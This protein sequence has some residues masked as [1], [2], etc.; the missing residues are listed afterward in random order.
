MAY[1]DNSLIIAFVSD[2]F[3]SSRIEAAA[4]ALDFHVLTIER[5][6]VIGLNNLDN[7]GVQYAEHLEVQAPRERSGQAPQ[8]QSGQAPQEQSGQGSTL[9]N[10]LT[11]P[12][13]ALII[14]D[15]GNGSISWRKWIPLIKSS[16]ATRRIPVLCFGAHMDAESLVA[17]RSAGADA[18]LARSKFVQSLAELLQKYARRIDYSALGEACQQKLSEIAIRGLDAFNR[19]EYFEAHE[20]LEEAWNHDP[21]PGRELYRAILQVAVAY[22]QI[23]RKNYRG[24]MKMFLRLRQW[25]DPLP[26]VCRGVNV[27]KLRSDARQVHESLQTLGADHIDEFDQ[28]LFT[29]VLFDL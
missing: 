27:A 8:E 20:I 11:Q 17:A 12:R 28:S 22:L 6:E 4:Q 21:T 10:M 26:D 16:P 23:E 18:V 15:L 14:F 3:F 2:L 5:D 13:P 25:I 19:G 29:P 24:A 7:D 1:N 9:L